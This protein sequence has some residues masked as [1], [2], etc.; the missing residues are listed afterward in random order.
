MRD[1]LRSMHFKIMCA[2]I[3]GLII[4]MIAVSA[5]GVWSAPQSTVFGAIFSPLQK[6][7][8]SVSDWVGDFFGAW[9]ERDRLRQENEELKGRVNELTKNL[10]D[11]DTYKHENEMY[12]D[13]LG[14]RDDY[15]DFELAPAKVISRDAGSEGYSF[16]ID[17]GSLQGV[18][19]HDPVI[20]ADGLVGYVSTVAP[21]YSTVTTLLDTSM[22][23][24]AIDSRTRGDTGVVTGSLDLA[25]KGLCRLNYLSP[26]GSAAAGDL[27]VTTGITGIFPK[28]LLIGTI[29]EVNQ[30]GSDI[31]AYAV[32]EPAADILELRDVLIITS[33][34]GQGGVLQEPTAAP[35]GGTGA[36][37]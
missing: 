31:S 25:S 12:K 17:K 13:Y 28:D 35:Q 16:S 29:R 10:I 15:P 26:T 2:V 19:P 4:I 14:F 5:T 30:S 32:I 7:G 1:F 18:S 27:V 22:N 24:A 36:A 9:G 20:T 21:T 8:A 34:N 11:F 3:V 37:E 33:F 6:A 23:V